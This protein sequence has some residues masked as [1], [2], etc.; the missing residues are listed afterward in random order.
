MANKSK[1]YKAGHDL[2]MDE[3]RTT[4]VNGLD[5]FN[6]LSVFI[7]F[8]IKT[9]GT[10]VDSNVKDFYEGVVDAATEQWNKTSDSEIQ[11]L[12]DLK[13]DIDSEIATRKHVA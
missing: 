7:N 3:I 8:V 12:N 13:K 10:P 6:K 9:V 5:E 11:E 1:S 2:A 4:L